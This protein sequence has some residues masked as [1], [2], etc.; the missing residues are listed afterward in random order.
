VLKG[1]MLLY[2]LSDYNSR[3][4]VDIDFLLRNQSNAL[5]DVKNMIA[6]IIDTQTEYDYISLASHS[7][8]EITPQRKYHGVSAQIIG[9]IKNIRTPFDIDIGIGDI[10]IPGAIRRKM[11]TQ[12]A[13]FTV[14]EIYTY[15]LESILAEKLDSILQ[16]YE[17]T[18]R[19]KD[20]YDIYYLSHSFDFNGLV[21][22]TAIYETLRN[23][24]TIYDINSFERIAALTDDPDIQI[25]WQ[26][27]LKKINDNT[28]S[29]NAVII[30]INTFLEPVYKSIINEN[31]FQMTWK[32]QLTTWL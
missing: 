15:S 10:I 26:Y 8:E 30:R 19:M 11:A 12:L 17:L 9:K 25:R 5:I 2:S 29:F 13:D 20:F 16:R 22:Q 1:G 24:G 28:L 23:R 7:F 4:T 21:L 14:P 31:E 32:H 27:F 3:A 6:D 18:G